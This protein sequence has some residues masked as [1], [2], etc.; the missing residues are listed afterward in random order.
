MLIVKKVRKTLILV[1]GVLLICFALLINSA[2]AESSKPSLL[3]PNLYPNLKSDKFVNTV[4]PLSSGWDQLYLNT[5]F[6]FDHNSFRNTS[7][8]KSGGG[9]FR[10]KTTGLGSN[11]DYRIEVYEADGGSPNPSKDDWVVG[12]TGIGNEDL[13][14]Y[15]QP[16]VDGANHK[17]ELYVRFGYSGYSEQGTVELDD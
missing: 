12:T 2:S 3:T 17:A 1:V 11:N 15:V 9:N 13:S 16:E 5:T 10:I 7:I 4:S 8:V 6:H 14:Y